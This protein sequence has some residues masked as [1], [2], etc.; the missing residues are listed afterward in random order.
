MGAAHLAYSRNALVCQPRQVCEYH[1][2]QLPTCV[3]RHTDAH[4][5]D[6]MTTLLHKNRGR[7]HW[8]SVLCVRF[9][10]L[11]ESD[12]AHLDV[13]VC[14]PVELDFEHLHGPVSHERAAFEH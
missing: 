13:E 6:G 4:I 5:G 12:L 2:L 9:P 3:H 8:P 10:R 1:F 11:S 7:S 14:Q